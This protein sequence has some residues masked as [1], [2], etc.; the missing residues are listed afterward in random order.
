MYASRKTPGPRPEL[1][2]GYLGLFLGMRV[3][4]LVRERMEA[5]GFENVRDS[6]GYVIQH[7]IEKERS[8]TELAER[9]E[10][11]QQAAS[12]FVVEL[13]ALGVIDV[14]PGSDRRAKKVRLSLRGWNLVR[15][16]RQTRRQ[17]EGRLI[18]AVGSEP[19]EQAKAILTAC[20]AALGG[21]EV[22]RGRKVLLPK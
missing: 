2:L 7:L 4:Q 11:T 10:V 13:E 14:V 3:N 19:Y 9:M 20:L 15:A 16:G 12:K 1:D 6:Y 8:I 17:V 22:V 5:A 21:M 18:R